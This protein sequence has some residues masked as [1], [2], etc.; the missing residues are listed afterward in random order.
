MADRLILPCLKS[1]PKVVNLSNKKLEKV[2]KSIGLLRNVQHLDLKNNSLKTLP[3]EF[4]ELEKVG[5]V[6]YKVYI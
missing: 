4:G 2:P 1:Q 5:N 3:Q 6:Y